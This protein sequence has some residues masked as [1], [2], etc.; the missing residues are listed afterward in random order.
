MRVYFLQIFVKSLCFEE[1]IKW[2][3]IL[4]QRAIL[5]ERGKNSYMIQLIQASSINYPLLQGGSTSSNGQ[6]AFPLPV[7]QGSPVILQRQ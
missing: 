3:P 4:F 5:E 2:C 7:Q 1:G 6:G